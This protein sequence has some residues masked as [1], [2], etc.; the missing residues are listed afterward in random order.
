[1]K[2]ID[3]EVYL[4]IKFFLSPTNN[5]NQYLEVQMLKILLRQLLCETKSNYW[6]SIILGTKSLP[7]D[8]Q[9]EEALT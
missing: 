6:N 1:M 5:K 4:S 9:G 7:K 8:V 2:V 3:M